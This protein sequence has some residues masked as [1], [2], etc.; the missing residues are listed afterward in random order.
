MKKIKNLVEQTFPQVDFRLMFKSHSSIGKHFSFKDKVEK[1]M[2]SKIIYMIE[3][4]SCNK[5]YVGKTIRHFCTR[6]EEHMNSSNSSVFKH[7]QETNHIIDWDN[8]KILD[9]ARDDKR[10][11][12]KEML[13]INKIKPELNIQ[14]SSKLFSLIIGNNPSKPTAFDILSKK[15]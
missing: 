11:L 5:S 14:K 3:C 1:D 4:A 15:K 9:T 6:K 10:L 12:L 2:K 8:M 13:Y 7:V